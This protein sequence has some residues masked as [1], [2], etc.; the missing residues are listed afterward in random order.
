MTGTPKGKRS[1]SKHQ[2]SGAMLNFGGVSGWVMKYFGWFFT[3]I[4]DTI[5]YHSILDTICILYN[6]YYMNIVYMHIGYY[7]FVGLV[8][9]IIGYP[10]STQYLDYVFRNEDA[11]AIWDHVYLSHVVLGWNS[12]LDIGWIFNHGCTVVLFFCH[13]SLFFFRHAWKSRPSDWFP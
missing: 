9:W 1:L 13:F 3:C 12:R 7:C 2:C 11:V 10:T 8:Y 4:L 6:V 5:L